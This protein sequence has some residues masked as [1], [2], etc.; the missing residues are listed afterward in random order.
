MFRKILKDGV[1][2]GL[3]NQ[4]EKHLS[5][6]KSDFCVL[7][8][9]GKL[10]RRSFECKEPLQSPR[11]L[12]R[13]HGD[14]CGPIDPPS[15]PFRFDELVFLGLGEDQKKQQEIPRQVYFPH[16]WPENRSVQID[17][18][19]KQCEQEVQRLLSHNRAA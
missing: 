10:I 11:F 1:V 2:T 14:I 16:D 13:L 7:C 15:G 12:E 6:L 19:T 18:P 5:K 17:P 8:A 9:K 4:L 3:P